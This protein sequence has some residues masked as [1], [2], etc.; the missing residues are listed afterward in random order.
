M[1][2]IAIEQVQ[3]F[4]L[5]RLF[6][7]SET[8]D[9]F[10]P[11]GTYTVRVIRSNGINMLCTD[12]SGY[13]FLV[14]LARCVKVSPEETPN[15]SSSHVDVET[16]SIIYRLGSGALCHTGPV[17]GRRDPSISLVS[18]A[19]A[20]GFDIL[21][22]TFGVPLNVRPDAAEP[23]FRPVKKKAVAPPPAPAPVVAPVE[24]PPAAEVV[25]DDFVIEPINLNWLEEVN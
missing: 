10:M 12:D 6:V 14:S 2:K 7:S 8:A 22:V 21:S 9:E 3:R 24:V 23:E 25:V 18:E 16:G 15:I 5:V 19:K 20:L 11:R 4:P 13:V 17:R 1:I